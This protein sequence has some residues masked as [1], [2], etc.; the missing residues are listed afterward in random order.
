[1]DSSAAARPVPCEDEPAA[2]VLPR[3]ARRST[4][5][6]PA[7]AQPEA[8]T[9]AASETAPA[10]ND[11]YSLYARCAKAPQA[12]VVD[13]D[14]DTVLIGA[15]GTRVRVPAGAFR[16]AR[17]GQPVTGP[18]QIRL[19]EYYALD[20]ILLANLTTSSG[21]RLLETGG[22]LY[23]A[24]RAGGQPCALVP[25]T[26]LTLEMPHAGAAQPGM[27]YFQGVRTRGR[28]A[29]DWQLPPVARRAPFQRRGYRRGA[30]TTAAVGPNP[31]VLVGKPRTLGRAL[32]RATGFCADSARRLAPPPLVRRWWAR[33]LKGEEKPGPAVVEVVKVQFDVTDS[34]AVRNV[35]FLTG[36]DPRLRAAVERVVR[37]TAWRPAT[38]FGAPLTTVG[39]S[40][41]VTFSRTGVIS[42]G[43][44][45]AWPIMPDA[46]NGKFARQVE[47][48]AAAGGGTFTSLTEAS[49]YVLSATQLGWINCD[50]F[51]DSPAPKVNLVVDAAA[52]ADI[53][54]VFRNQRSVMSGRA[55]GTEVTFG[56]LPAGEAVTILA[57]RHMAGETQIATRAIVIGARTERDLTFRAVTVPALRQ[58]LR[59]LMAAR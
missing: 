6:A 7:A 33:L 8:A 10:R 5:Y 38:W 13:A 48:R 52:D 36:A 46:D 3:S 42:T 16:D 18:V 43:F 53:K 14:A 31:L 11:I 34:G 28:R 37:E 50:R 29:L 9:E 39:V 56:N 55:V 26:A 19:R 17:T 32:R 21:A 49:T 45:S 58:E 35:V 4:A 40:L 12:F 27:Q 24:A 1:M 57:L 51:S 23:V 59:G 20:D 41:R 2:A 25:G 22:M 15:E 30:S 54:L 44:N 47:A